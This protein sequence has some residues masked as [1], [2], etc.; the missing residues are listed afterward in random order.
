LQISAVI[1]DDKVSVE[2]LE[3]KIVAFE[4]LV[5][6]AALCRYSYLF[7]FLFARSSS[8]W[9]YVTLS[10]V[11]RSF[12]SWVVETFPVWV[13]LSLSLVGET[14]PLLSSGD[15]TCLG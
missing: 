10:W 7:V 2:E 8:L 14:F 1:V 6:P 13:G 4:D 3:E 12:M 15:S 11:G 9:I 5:R